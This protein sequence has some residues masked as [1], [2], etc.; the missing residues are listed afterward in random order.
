MTL[1]VYAC[2]VK[3][4]MFVLGEICVRS[5]KLISDIIWNGN[6]QEII[7]KDNPRVL[8]E[9]PKLV[10]KTAQGSLTYERQSTASGF[11]YGQWVIGVVMY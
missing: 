10:A 5:A 1:C 6:A 11:V 8:E 7:P 9:R 4:Y 3:F 2:L